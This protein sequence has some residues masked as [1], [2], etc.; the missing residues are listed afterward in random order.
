MVRLEAVDEVTE[1]V[2]TVSPVWDKES[3]GTSRT[4]MCGKD[5]PTFS[6]NTEIEF[7]IP[8]PLLTQS[9]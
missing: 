7:H 4:D 3:G 9:T 1:A 6:Q 5:M 8:Q 2:V